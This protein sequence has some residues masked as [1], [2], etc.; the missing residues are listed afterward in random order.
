[1]TRRSQTSACQLARQ[2]N[3]AKWPL[4]LPLVSSQLRPNACKWLA[5]GFAKAR[6]EFAGCMV[7]S[8]Y[9]GSA[10][11]AAR[12]PPSPLCSS[13][14]GMDTDLRIAS[15][16]YVIGLDSTPNS[17]PTT[18]VRIAGG[19]PACPLAMVVMACFW[20]ADA[21]SSII[22]PTDQL[23]LPMISGV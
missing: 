20:S 9:N 6:R 14:L 3:G 16:L 18:P 19:P 12:G 17:F 23:P 22:K 15:F 13:M 11:V 4:L 1:V 21:R 10:G 2:L 7:L 8:I 5:K